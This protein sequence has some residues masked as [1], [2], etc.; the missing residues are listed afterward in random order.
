[1]HHVS[2]STR[3]SLSRPDPD[4]ASPQSGTAVTINKYFFILSAKNQFVINNFN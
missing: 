3:N 4:M 2:T 1:M